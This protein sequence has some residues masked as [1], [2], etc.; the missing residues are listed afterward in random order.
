[1]INLARMYARNGCKIFPCRESGPK[2]KIKAPYTDHGYK[3]ASADAQQIEA[4]WKKWPNAIVGVA[5]AENGIIVLDGDRHDENDGVAAIEAI[6]ADIGFDKANVPVVETPNNGEHLYFMMPQYGEPA[7]SPDKGVDVKF[8]GY[9]IA[10]GSRFADGREYRLTN[11]TPEELASVI[12]KRDLREIPARFLQA[13]QPQT[14]V[15]ELAEKQLVVSLPNDEELISRLSEKRRNDLCSQIEVG[16][17]SKHVFRVTGWLKEDGFTKDE[18]VRLWNL[19]P[20]GAAAK[21]IARKSGIAGE[22]ARTWD[23]LDEPPE[24]MDISGI[25]ATAPKPANTPPVGQPISARD[26]LAMQFQ[27]VNYV[28]PGYIADG[29]SLLA[30]AP[31]IGKSWLV[32]EIA[33]AIASGGTCLGGIQCVRGDVLYLA[34]EDNRRRVQS[35]LKIMLTSAEGEF[36]DG[37][38]F[39]TDWPRAEEGVGKLRQWLNDHPNARLVIIDVLARV[40]AGRKTKD[41]QQYDVDYL[42]VSQLQQL[43]NEFGIAVVVVH[44]TRKAK[45]DVDPFDEISGTLGLSGAADTALVLRQTQTGVVLYG[46]GRDIEEIETAVQFDSETCKWVPLGNPADAHR[47]RER[48]EIRDCLKR[49]PRGLLSAEISRELARD[50]NSV[51]QLLHKMKKSGDVVQLNAR[52]PYLHPDHNKPGFP[53]FIPGNNGNKDTG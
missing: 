23:R 35:R 9:V 20:T 30:G 40:K 24:L 10:P 48:T 34:L 42:A 18:A 7:P 28:V 16:G 41:Q 51:R 25:M 38:Y 39:D 17:R 1:M 2:G 6:L 52:G 21:F 43:A 11:R 3:D 31:K 22:I 45:A 15:A 5:C 27:P 8:N 47:T 4:W 44:H 37:L 13:R 19:H 36:P 26:L 12:Q 32:M 33:T 50:D 46:R 49:F 14:V 29:L 53:L